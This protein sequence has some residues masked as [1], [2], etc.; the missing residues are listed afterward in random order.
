[1]TNFHLEKIAPQCAAFGVSLDGEVGERLCAYG[2]LLLEWNEKMNLT[3]ITEPEEILYKHFYDCLLLLK[4][5]S[6]PQGA[7]VIDIGTGA[8]F[9]GLVLKIAR[10]DLSL[11]LLDGLNKRLI[12][13]NAVLSALGLSADTVHRRAEEG[14]RDPA[15]RERFDFAFA[16][17]VAALP[18]LCEYCLPFVK[19]GGLF[20]AMKGAG[21]AE[22]AAAAGHAAAL[23]GGAR[24]AILCET[25]TGN[26]QRAFISIQKISQTSPKYPRPGGK[27]AKSAL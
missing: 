4:D 13:L 8:G 11:T 3:A 16:R 26:E 18:V 7:R 22:E 23:L 10:P 9:P 5:F 17:A 2:E 14:G 25:L 21:A 20:V 6:L 27:I 24:P 1:M 12:F 15:L 19:K